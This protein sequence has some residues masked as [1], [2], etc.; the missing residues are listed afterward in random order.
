MIMMVGQLRAEVW[1]ISHG[2]ELVHNP[3]LEF[4]ASVP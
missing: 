2:K 4:Q 3:N 1:A